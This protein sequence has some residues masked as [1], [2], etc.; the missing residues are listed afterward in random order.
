MENVNIQTDTE[1]AWNWR[2]VYNTVS[3]WLESPRE[4]S[5]IQTQ[6]NK[7]GIK[8][9]R[10]KATKQSLQVV[11]YTGKITVCLHWLCFDYHFRTGNTEREIM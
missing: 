8:H 1:A 3:G 4:K 6:T 11:N 5:H 9:L 7:Q 10:P 2:G